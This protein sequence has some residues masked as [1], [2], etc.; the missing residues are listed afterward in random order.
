MKKNPLLILSASIAG[1]MAMPTDEV[2]PFQNFVWTGLSRATIVSPAYAE[3]TEVTKY[4]CPMHPQIIFDEPGQCPICGMNLVAI[5]HGHDDKGQP[6][7]KNGNGA[8]KTERKILY[9]YDPMVPGKKFDQPG[10]SPFMD[11]ELVPKYADDAEAESGN[12]KPVVTIAVDML[13]KMGVR[14]EKV[15]KAQ[16]SSRL[17]AT[18]IVMNN[19]RARHNIFTQV[20]G[21]V[22][23]L[24]YSAPG[25]RVKKGDLFYTLYSPELLALQGDYL[26]ALKSG[27]KDL[28]ASARKR[29]ILLGVGDGVLNDI[30]KSGKAYDSVPFYIPADGIL[31]DLEIRQGHYL[32]ANAGIAD[33]QDLSTVW[34]EAAVPEQDIA[35]LKEGDS[36]RV[37]VSGNLSSFEAKVDY[38]YPAITPE[39]RT[40]KVRL[41]IENPDYA[42]K[43]AGYAVVSF[44][45]GSG[46][47]MLLAP[48]SAILH[49]S[50]GDHVIVGLGGGKFQARDVKTGI[51]SGGQTEILEGLSQG[52]DVVINGQFLIDSESNLR[53]ALQKISSGDSNGK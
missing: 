30:T 31:M 41:V 14:T 28:A 25:D 40:G 34:I 7:D 50:T 12:G 6:E 5:D 2:R 33:I 47:E 32:E 38:I 21:R 42:L 9:W 8:E 1:I 44:A 16:A 17:R 20:E 43:P 35:Q 27:Y 26:A 53:E 49:D 24:N 51:S 15:S 45:A 46:M 13:Q 3:E 29:M 48:S 4:T 10:K 22:D 36:A 19:E 23:H 11:M 39:T 52:E 18:G 37:E